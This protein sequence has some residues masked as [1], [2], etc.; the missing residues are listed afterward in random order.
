MFTVRSPNPAHNGISAGV[1][2]TAGVGH[3]DSRAALA[4]F[5]KVGYQITRDDA[6]TVPRVIGE[7]APAVSIPTPEAIVPVAPSDEQLEDDPFA[8][9]P[10]ASAPVP[11]PATPKRR[12]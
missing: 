3:T 2:F 7:S 1:R 10:A 11:R 8:P 5:A 4:Y 12:R 9:A 6:P